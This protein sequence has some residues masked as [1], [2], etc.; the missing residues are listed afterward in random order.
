[1]A[2]DPRTMIG[3]SLAREIWTV[4]ERFAALAK[5]TRYLS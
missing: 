1:V 5:E 3:K 4:E 2:H